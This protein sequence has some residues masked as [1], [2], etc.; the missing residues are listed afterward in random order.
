MKFLLFLLIFILG[1]AAGITGG[2]LRLQDRELLIH[3]D[4]PALAY[5]HKVSNCKE[6]SWAMR[7]LGKKCYPEQVIDIYD[8]NKKEDRMK[9]INAAFTCKSKARFIY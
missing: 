5:P 2:Q 9:L 4:K 3:P 1:C 8:M 7:W 6:R